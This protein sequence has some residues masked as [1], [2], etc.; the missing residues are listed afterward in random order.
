MIA[1]CPS[2]F[3]AFKARPCKRRQGAIRSTYSFAGSLDGIGDPQRRPRPS[4]ISGTLFHS[5][6]ARRMAS[7]GWRRTA[8]GTALD[9]LR[10]AKGCS[11]GPDA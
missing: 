2:G 11:H 10:G 3:G 6:R 4:D 1:A 9:L 7:F 5:P 8:L